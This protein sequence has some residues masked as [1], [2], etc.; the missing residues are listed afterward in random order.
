MNRSLPSAAAPRIHTGLVLNGLNSSVQ[1]RLLRHWNDDQDANLSEVLVALDSNQAPNL[2]LALKAIIKSVIVQRRDLE[3]YQSFLHDQRRRAPVNYDLEL[4]Q[5]FVRQEQLSK[6]VISIRDVEIFDMTLLADLISALSSWVDRIPI[7]LLFG[8]ATTVELLDARL[9]R[10]TLNMIQART[11]DVS[12]PGDSHLNVYQTLQ[13]SS[14]TKLW[15]GP[16]ISRTL[17]ERVK[18]DDESPES[19]LRCFEYAYMGHFF[20]NPLSILLDDAVS[21]NSKPAPELC[22]AIRKTESFR[23]YAQTFMDA[24][25]TKSVLRLL[26]DDKFLWDEARKAVV[27]GQ[28]SMNAFRKAVQFFIDLREFLC[29]PETTLLSPFEIDVQAYSGTSFLDT[30][31]FEDTLS[32]IQKLPSL[33]LASLLSRISTSDSDL[34]NS[35]RSITTKLDTLHAANGSNSVRSLH[36]PSH[37]TTSTAI[38][39]HNTVSLT[40]HAPKLT[41]DEKDYT[42]IIDEL[43]T[44]VNTYFE[45]TILDVNQL[46]MNEVFVYDLK[47][48]LTGAFAPRPRFVIERALDRPGDY[49]GCECC[50]AETEGM[51][52]NRA[53]PTSLLWQLWC[54]AG[55]IVNVRDLWGA[56][57]AV[58]VDDKQDDD[59]DDEEVDELQ[60]KHGTLDGQRENSGIDE[61][62]ALALFYRGLAEMRMLGFV[63]PTKRKVDC[64][65]KVTWRG[66]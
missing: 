29:R 52:R 45:E 32:A 28:Q 44:E 21:S 1:R 54:E 55:N 43:H 50:T 58:L 62:M 42:A 48:P 4:L 13:N 18:E 19:L 59:D 31:I 22:D 37:T 17:A 41:K 34:A 56:F 39:R 63:K 53:P 6:V 20:A 64:L 57:C 5:I 23:L 51:E 30:L 2:A 16:T 24:G 35:V 26:N 66:L 36:D 49:L 8:I 46:F 15:L 27:E 7:V 47:M 11:F 12:E 14:D 9:P 33:E 40:K 65:A 25:D 60:S 38:S 3:Y 61:R 10:K